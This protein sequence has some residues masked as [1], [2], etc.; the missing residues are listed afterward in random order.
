MLA[1]FSDSISIPIRSG[2][3]EDRA[4]LDIAHSQRLLLNGAHSY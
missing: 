4:P 2:S 3:E 1:C